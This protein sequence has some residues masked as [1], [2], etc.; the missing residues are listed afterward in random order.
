MDKYQW[1]KFWKKTQNQLFGDTS[2]EILVFFFFLVVSTGFWILQALDE[3]FEM[4][5][6]FPLELTDVP[7]DVV[8]TSP[9]PNEVT[10]K[11]RDRGTSL[12]H[13]WNRKQEPIE[14]SFETY[15]NGVNYGHCVVTPTELMKDIN[16]RLL[17][18]SKILSARPDT[19]DFYYNHGMHK[20]VPAKI[21]GTIESWP[22]AYVQN[23]KIEPHE[24]TVYASPLILDT[25]KAVYT[26]TISINGMRSDSTFTSSLR[27]IKGAKMTPSK[28]TVSVNL[29]TYMEKSVVVPI[30]SANF[31]GGKTLKPFPSQVTITYTSGYEQGKELTEK[32]FPIV[33]TYEELLKLQHEGESQLPIHLKRLPRGVFNIRISPETVDYLIESNE[34]E[35]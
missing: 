30:T 27:P 11:L 22:Q 33:V 3:T 28:V 12:I 35:E 23:I 18:T 21:Q 1:Q 24:V 15:D 20:T 6:T 25:L 4:E 26:K 32:D 2:R 8:I 5:V 19:V 16:D 7:Q 29:D 14:I 17:S 9:L 31:P 13:Y 34:Q 10:V